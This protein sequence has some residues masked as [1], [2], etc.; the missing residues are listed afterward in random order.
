MRP[1]FFLL[2]LLP[3]G[4]SAQGAF[5]IFDQ[6]HNDVTGGIFT[7]NDTSLQMVE[8]SFMIENADS[9][10]SFTVT[11]GRMVISAPASSSNAITWNSISYPPN[12]DSSSV[13]PLMAP[14][15]SLPLV[16]DYFPNGN[17]GMATINY[18]AWDRFDMNNNSCVTVSF[19][20]A[21]ALGTAAQ[22]EPQ[23]LA[24][25][26]PV[27]AGNPLLLQWDRLPGTWL[28]IS[29]VA[30]SGERISFRVPVSAQSFELSTDDLL[31]GVYIT[32]IA[33]ENGLLLRQK[34]VVE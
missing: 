22:A 4:L 14:F 31:P 33:T 3:V 12:V 28:T 30:V 23:L 34:T 2:F 1:L 15:D 13:D 21:S 19:N 17:P 27:M 29:L 9:V 16:A 5:R 32:E 6:L 11:A 8:T 24:G 10:N 26:S 20:I 7:V 18:C 25:P